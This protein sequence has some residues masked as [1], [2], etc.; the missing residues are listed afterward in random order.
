MYQV[1]DTV[2]GIIVGICGGLIRARNW[3]NR[4]DRAIG[5]GSNRYAVQ[6]S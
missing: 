6:K 5:P 1:I 2:T 4:L 3:A